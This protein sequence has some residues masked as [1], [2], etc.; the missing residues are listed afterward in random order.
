MKKL[1]L[2]LFCFILSAPSA[3]ADGIFNTAKKKN[4][5][6]DASVHNYQIPEKFDYY[7]LQNKTVPEEPSTDSSLVSISLSDPK[8]MNWSGALEINPPQDTLDTEKIILPFMESYPIENL[9]VKLRL[10]DAKF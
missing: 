8:D 7:K 1:L 3:N 10:L 4:K 2:F 5:A 9:E 6:P